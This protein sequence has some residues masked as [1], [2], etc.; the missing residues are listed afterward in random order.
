MKVWH[1]DRFGND[2]KLRARADEKL[3][4][5]NEAYE[6]LSAMFEGRSKQS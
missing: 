3:K 5:I 1:P 6:K 2:P 4:E